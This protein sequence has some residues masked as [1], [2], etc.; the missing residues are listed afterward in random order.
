[1]RSCLVALVLASVPARAD[2]PPGRPA[3]PF[4]LP[5]LDGKRVAL[6]PLRGKVVVLDFWASW[7]G[8]CKEELP[9]LEKLKAAY[10]A[11]GVAFVTV[12]LDQ[13]RGNAADLVK[14]LRLTLPVGLDPGGKVAD[15]YQLPAMPTSFV[16]DRAGVVRHV[17]AGYRGS[18]DAAQLA[19]EIDGLLGA[20]SV[21]AR[22]AATR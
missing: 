5:G 4:D 21:P 10:E 1:M 19:R 16:I 11:R 18:S 15:A 14:R 20:L 22:R 17:H 7:C 13:D 8:P 6:A 9:A 12:N 2:L 3:P